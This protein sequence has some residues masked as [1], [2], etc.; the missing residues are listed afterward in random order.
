MG[1]E[2]TT[3]GGFSHV[4][5]NGETGVSTRFPQDMLIDYVRVY[6]LD[7]DADELTY[8]SLPLQVT[9]AARYDTLYFLS[10]I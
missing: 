10:F 4:F 1:Y 9:D 8:N 7:A 6:Q 5:N 2:I 3:F